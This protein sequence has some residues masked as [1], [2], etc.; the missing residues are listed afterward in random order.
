[1]ALTVPCA[2]RAEVVKISDRP[3]E[4]VPRPQKPAIHVPE[5]MRSL[6]LGQEKTQLTHERGH[7][8]RDGRELA[9]AVGSK[10]IALRWVLSRGGGSPSLGK[11]Q[12][13]DARQPSPSR[14]ACYGTSWFRLPAAGQPVPALKSWISELGWRWLLLCQSGSERLPPGR[15]RWRS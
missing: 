12:T 9:G 7:G 8:C 13:V 10:R 11:G 4:N 6:P 1:M 3:G 2:H 14:S 5:H 15:P